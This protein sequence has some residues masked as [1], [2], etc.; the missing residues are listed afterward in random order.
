MLYRLSHRILSENRRSQKTYSVLSRRQSSYIYSWGVGTDGQLGVGQVKM[1]RKSI[2]NDEIHVGQTAR[3][4][5]ASKDLDFT[6]VAIGKS[7]TLGVTSSGFLYGWGKLWGLGNEGKVSV[8]EPTALSL[9]P[10]FKKVAAG[11]H[12]GCA[13]D[14]D[15]QVYT[16][17]KYPSADGGFFSFLSAGPD[18]GWLGHGNHENCDTPTKI[19]SFEEYGAT[20]KQV[21]CGDMHTLILTDDGEVLSC[22]VGESG[23]L[24][25]GNT[26]VCMTPTSIDALLN[27]TVTQIAAGASCSYALTEGGDVYAWGTNAR[28]QLGVSDTFIDVNSVEQFPVLTDLTELEGR[29][30]NQVS[31]CGSRA[32]ILTECGQVF[33]WGRGLMHRPHRLLLDTYYENCGQASDGRDDPIVSVSFGGESS[34]HALMMV[35]ASGRLLSMG[36][37]GSNLLARPAVI[38]KQPIARIEAFVPRPKGALPFVTCVFGG[39]GQHMACMV[40]GTRK[41]EV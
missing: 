10:K 26:D 18:G 11:Q 20:A 40:D 15:G 17:G 23:R 6:D 31:A 9:E 4:I 41:V 13:V 22:G 21:A 1:N 35:T 14:A 2:S 28:G 8:L 7:F 19:A 36:D 24:G 3:R 39:R 16:F 38:G 34:W 32:A 27:E 33:T 5:P 37:G 29:R 12:H 25:T 30:V